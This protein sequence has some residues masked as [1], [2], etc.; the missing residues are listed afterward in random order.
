[1]STANEPLRR[2]VEEGGRG[3]VLIVG[4]GPT[5]LTAAMELSRLGVAVRIVDKA[6]EP[7]TTSKAL[8][9]QARTL[10]LLEPRGVGA[11]MVRLGNKAKATTLYGRGKRLAAVELGRVPSRHNY[12][13]LLPQDETERLLRERLA[14]QGVEVERG[15]E[16]TS[17]EQLSSAPDGPPGGVRATLRRPGGE[18]EEVEASYLIAADGKYSAVRSALDL[19]FEGRSLP[20]RFALADLYVEGD[21][22]EDELS[23][24]LAPDGFLAAFPMGNHRFRFMA[25]DPERRSKDA[26]KPTLEEMQTVYDHVAHIPARLHDTNWSSRFRVESRHMS[27]LR[28]GDVFFGGDAAHVHSP[29]GGQ[30][31]NTGVQDMINLSW[32]LAMVLRGQADPTLL[33]T[34]GADRLPVISGVV[35]TTE[36]ATNVFV[37][38]NPVVHG[39]F[40]RIA[41]IALSTDRVQ[42]K[43]TRTIGEVAA[44]YRKSPLSAGAADRAGLRAGDRVPDLDLS[45]YPEGHPDGP[46]GG[47][48]PHRA[49]LYE[50]LDLSRFTLLVVEPRNAPAGS[51]RPDWQERLEPWRDLVAT[52][53]VT[54]EPD[55]PS[56][57]AEHADLVRSLAGQGGLL[58]VR[59][60]GY[61]GGGAPLGD[62]STLVAWLERWFSPA[63]VASPAP[64]A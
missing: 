55:Q 19:P 6:A 3:P 63:R 18:T 51:P 54:P 2:K 62:P 14:G 28:S 22:P 59:P 20:Q 17:F 16:M 25:A 36:T 40:T 56:Q 32:K 31:M 26:E 15:V 42:N 7:S 23:I 43:G 33:D 38:Q 49:R 41:P 35:R 58:L 9:V 21:L 27:T 53:R 45:V 46:P 24:F 1:M 5:G 61:L 29:A 39:L 8:A 13:L 12:V 52:R 50:L 44:N 37:S 10:E 57:L 60:D 47:G 4:A 64:V 11:E 30:G 34:Y 48:E